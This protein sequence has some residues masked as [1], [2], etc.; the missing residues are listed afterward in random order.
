MKTIKQVLDGL[1]RSPVKSALTLLTVGLGVGVLI[2]V[3]GMTASIRRSVEKQL[4]TE[5]Y[6]LMVANAEPG[7][8]GGVEPVRPPQF[9]ASVVDALLSDVDGLI[10]VTPVQSPPW[11][12]FLV[13]ERR[14]RIRA[15]TAASERYVEVMRLE[16]AAGSYF[17][18]EDVASG[19][20]RA[21]I[22]ESLA[23]VLFGSASNAI[24]G[25]IS[26]PA[27]TQ[28]AGGTGFRTRRFAPPSFEVCGVV[29]N[30]PELMRRAYGVGDLIVPFTSI[31]PQGVNVG[32][33]ISF[34]YG[35]LAVRVRGIEIE[36]ASAQIR[37]AITRTY[38]DEAAVMVWEGAAR[39]ESAYLS[40]LRNTISSFSTVGSILGFV[41]LAVASIGIMSIMLVETIGRSRDVAL[42]RAFGAS[43]G[44]I[45][46]EYFSK[47]VIISLLSGIVGAAVAVVFAAPL[48][49]LVKPIFSGYGGV[50]TIDSVV[51]PQAVVV[52]LVA[53]TAFGG[54]FGV[55][56]VFALLRTPIA[57][58]LRDV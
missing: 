19:A 46:A 6:V 23:T 55:I 38:G 18:A 28:G 32:R 44:R 33:I 48:T 45:V 13:G 36:K 1:A 3:L 58:G 54:L 16:L 11:Q 22:T 39:G 9:D 40:D 25:V 50:S 10:A 2:L 26:V 47:S 14:Y 49:S 51:S 12:D 7:D 4:H 41:L 56:P 53:A 17:T 42:E 57:E 21:L 29:K 52:A 5:G 8:E 24:G 30:P 27:P 37:R 15:A 31:I 43:R 20:G 35:T 34:F